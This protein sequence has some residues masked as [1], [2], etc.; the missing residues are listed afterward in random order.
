MELRGQDPGRCPTRPGALR[1]TGAGW[2]PP[3]PGP[4]GLHPVG[5]L[6][7]GLWARSSVFSPNA[8]SVPRLGGRGWSQGPGGHEER[9]GVRP[10]AWPSG[11]S[12]WE[13]THGAGW[14]A[15]TSECRFL[16]CPHRKGPGRAGEDR[17]KG[18]L[19]LT[20]V[21]LTMT[22]PRK[23]VAG[24]RDSDGRGDSEAEPQ[25]RGKAA[26]GLALGAAANLGR[27]QRLPWGLSGVA[28]RQPGLSAS[29]RGGVGGRPAPQSL[30][31]LVT[32]QSR[33]SLWVQSGQRL[34]G[35]VWWRDTEKPANHMVMGRWQLPGST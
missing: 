35:E 32:G 17:L 23:C 27:R 25:P 14:P 11:A 15:W 16:P 9:P 31:P 10:W 1:G 24:S 34:S 13:L 30:H 19:S 22:R 33:G 7:A 2:L 6:V 12:F 3:N 28:V 4:W 20:A 29:S 26:R 8:G 21:P 5:L 18:I